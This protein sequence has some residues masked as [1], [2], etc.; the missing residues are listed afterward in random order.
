MC[1]P[2]G[3][4]IAACAVGVACTRNQLT[5]AYLVFCIFSGI[6]PDLDLLVGWALGDIN[7]YH[8]LGSHSVVAA[9]LYGLLVY[10]F[11]RTI[12]KDHGQA[13]GWAVSG[14]LM[15]TSHVLL[16]YLAADSSPPFGLQ[17]L[18]PFSREFFIS[19]VSVFMKFMHDTQGADMWGLIS[20]M[21]V[22]HNFYAV[23]LETVLL[24]PLLLLAIVVRK[25]THS[26]P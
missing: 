2:I 4:I 8:H 25:R 17:L 18:W 9:L 24:L 16:D 6:A 11:A 15:Y 3:H 26:I 19:P 23:V 21:F 5:P 12:T 10:V 14:T 1:S 22:V 20:G 13:K 7:A